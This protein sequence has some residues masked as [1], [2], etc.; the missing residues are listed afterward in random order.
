VLRVP[1]SPTKRAL[2]WTFLFL[3]L[4]VLLVG[5]IAFTCLFY[6]SK[7]VLDAEIN[8]QKWSL[9]STIYADAPMI[10][11]GMPAKAKWLAEYLQRMD[12]QKT[13]SAELRPGEYAVTKDG[14][15]FY[16]HQLFSTQSGVFP[17]EV[18]F[19]KN[20][21]A[22]LTNLRSNEE[23]P[24]S[25]LEPIP[26]SNLFGAEWEKRTLVHIQDLPKCLPD[27]VVAIEDRRF[28][29]HHGVDLRA[30]FRAVVN[31]ALGRKQLQGGSTITQQLVK[32]FYLTPERSIKR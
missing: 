20:G 30:I 2:L 9:P 12:Y 21:I 11:E 18:K 31:D 25:E 10:Y 4:I 27:A 17:L 32:N 5:A 6:T 15:A 8:N 29:E 1:K 26:I 19:D 23:V 24:A 22:T 7:K 3:V 13:E 14:L 16:K 28:Y